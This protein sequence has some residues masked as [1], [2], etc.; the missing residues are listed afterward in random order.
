MSS[1][2]WFAENL[3]WTEVENWWTDPRLAY[4]AG[5]LEGARLERERQAAHDDAGHRVAVQQ[6]VRVID[7]AQ[8]RE[9]ADRR[10]PRPGD[11]ELDLCPGCNHAS[12]RCP[13]LE[14]VPFGKWRSDRSRRR[15][16]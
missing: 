3:P 9:Q 4:A 13:S 16:A 15:T 7:A 14:E 5:L 10:D 12:C 11:Q 1:K 8:A 2:P 6:A